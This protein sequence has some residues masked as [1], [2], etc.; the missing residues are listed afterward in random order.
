MSG[1]RNR[2][3]VSVWGFGFGSVAV[4]GF[5]KRFVAEAVKDSA[6]TVGKLNDLWALYVL[7]REDRLALS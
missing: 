7:E 2:I 3:S 5:R 1:T 6:E 4:L